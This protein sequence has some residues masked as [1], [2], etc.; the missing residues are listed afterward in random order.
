MG[1]SWVA[2]TSMICCP[3]GTGGFFYLNVFPVRVQCP[4]SALLSGRQFDA[5]GGFFHSLVEVRLRHKGRVA[6][7]SVVAFHFPYVFH[8]EGEGGVVAFVIIKVVVRRERRTVFALQQ[9]RFLDLSH[10]LSRSVDQFSG[11]FLQRTEHIAT[12]EEMCRIQSLLVQNGDSAVS[13][14]TDWVIDLQ[15]TSV[16]ASTMT[17]LE[18]SA[19]PCARTG[20]RQ[21]LRQVQSSPRSRVREW[22]IIGFCYYFILCSVLCRLA[23]GYSFF[24]TISS[25]FFSATFSQNIL[26]V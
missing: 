18:L 25:L 7:Q 4:M 26:T 3:S 16:C 5:V 19:M 20:R 2:D 23:A 17:E 9:F 1:G 22:L 6:Y 12:T 8:G 13:R 24:S 21:K 15:I 14:S 11:E 10:A